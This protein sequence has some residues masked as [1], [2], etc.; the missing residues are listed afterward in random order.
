MRVVKNPTKIVR[1]LF[2]TTFAVLMCAA[3]CSTADMP[4]SSGFAE[5]VTD[6]AR[7]ALAAWLF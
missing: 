5:F 7:E 1:R 4:S 2:I 3:G 6:F